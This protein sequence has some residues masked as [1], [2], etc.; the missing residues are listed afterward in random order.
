MI[1]GGGKQKGGNFERLI[2]KKLSLWVS[3]GKRDDIFWR[4]AMSGGR[5]TVGLKKGI[6]RT[7]QFGDITAIDPMGQKLIDTFIIECK[8]Y[9]NIQLQSMLFGKPKDNSIYGFWLKLHEQATLLCKDKMLII[10]P[11]NLSILICLDKDSCF[12]Q[13]LR[14]TYDIKPLAVFSN[15]EPICYLYEFTHVLNLVDPADITK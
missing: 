5:A 14:D 8:A 10:R 15:I 7:N 12:R 11:N 2:C 1:S 13:I 4:S 6:K 9:K 3:Y